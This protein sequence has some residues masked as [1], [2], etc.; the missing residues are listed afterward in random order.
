MKKFIKAAKSAAVAALCAAGMLSLSGCENY[1]KMLR[2]SPDE[3]IDMAME[4][5]MESIGG[6]TFTEEKKLFEQAL[7]DGSFSLGFEVEGI[8]FNGVCEVN[9]K[10][11]AVSQM[12]TLSNAEGNSAQVYVYADKDSF[13]FGTIGDSGSHIYDVTLES[14]AEK[15]AASIFAPDSDS[16]Y[17]MSETDYNA[18][19]EYVETLSA[20]MENADSN[21]DDKYQKLFE[22][23]KNSLDPAIEEKTDIDIGG[24]T[25]NAN[26]VTYT[27]TTDKIKD[28]LNKLFDLLAEDGQLDQETTGYSAEELRERF[29]EA[30]S[31]I[32]EINVTAKYDINAKTNMLMQSDISL[33]VTADDE[34][35]K[36]HFN[37]FFGADPAS[38]EKQTY[39]FSMK[40]DSEDVD[41]VIVMDVIHTETNTT[42][43]AKT[44]NTVESTELFTINA[45]KSGEN[46]SLS[47]DIM[48]EMT[49]GIEGTIS[50][51]GN[52]FDMTIDK[53]SAG[54][55][56]GEFSYSPNAKVNVKKGGE[57]FVLDAEGEFLDI[58]E[59]EMYTLL[60]NIS[61]DFGWLAGQTSGALT[62]SMIGYVAQADI[63]NA[64]AN[65][66]GV[67]TA[68]SADM[69]QRYVDDDE[70]LVGGAI[71]GSG[72][73]FTVGGVKVD[74][75]IYLG[76]DFTGYVYG[77]ANENTFAVEYILWSDQPIP[78]EYKHQ[79]TDEEQEELNKK[80]I[81]IG[82]Y[83]FK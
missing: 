8:I 47:V 36:M 43:T 55:G 22:D 37:S 52:T 34:T 81:T 18:L 10:S 30:M 4:N 51:S 71:E 31:S 11:N 59:A 24:E 35:M 75:S 60:E 73:D 14:F 46:Y 54:Y 64:N 29:D 83:P 38:A 6:N 26:T 5:T 39:T 70:N 32:E 53:I 17:A 49:A 67:H 20:A 33:N 68:C 48:G 19:L 50:T 57:I 2:D 76:N 65:A 3:Y 27:V 21:G 12:Y 80:G 15:L 58:T 40:A 79:L 56:S 62:S 9:E 28:L 41:I 77:Y 61:G 16:A 78:D 1:G 23:F 25:V 45:E 13:K 42:I 69:A 63:I 74:M 66:K 72:P 82:C 7:E 44:A